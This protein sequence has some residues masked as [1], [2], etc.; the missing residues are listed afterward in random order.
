MGSI[1][2][3]DGEESNSGT[4]HDYPSGAARYSW[5]PAR[6][7]VSPIRRCDEQ[8]QTC[9]YQRADADQANQGL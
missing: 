2:I 5:S 3:D 9:G 7:G 8:E 4:L 6:A 1:E